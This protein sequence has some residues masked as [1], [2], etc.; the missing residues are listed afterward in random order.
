MSNM[1]TAA[2]NFNSDLSK[3][4]VSKVTS[5]LEMFNDAS[6]FK[7]DLTKWDVSKVTEHGA[8]FRDYYTCIQSSPMFHQCDCS[9]ELCDHAPARFQPACKEVCHMTATADKTHEHY[10]VLV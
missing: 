2:S 1:F 3:W 6:K 9:A 7:S 4:N 10:P 5:M 8:M